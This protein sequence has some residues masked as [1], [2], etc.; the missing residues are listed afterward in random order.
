[1]P[2]RVEVR[3]ELIAEVIEAPGHMPFALFCRHCGDIW[4]R[5]N[6]GE[7]W[8]GWYTLSRL[9]PEHGGGSFLQ[10]YNW[11]PDHQ[12]FNTPG[13]VRWEF[14]RLLELALKEL[15]NE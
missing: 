6:R 7:H 14:D 10:S 12:F 9:C 11:L 15:E 8:A 13:L 4:G 5:V 3:G 2:T 1:M